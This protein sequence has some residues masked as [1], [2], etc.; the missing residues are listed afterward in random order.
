MIIINNIHII[1][2]DPKHVSWSNAFMT[3]LEE[4]QSYVK[5]YHTTGL[6]WNPNGKDAQE[7]AG[8]SIKVNDVTIT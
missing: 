3:I 7:V 8:K 1:N 5:A 4:L 2:S 6:V